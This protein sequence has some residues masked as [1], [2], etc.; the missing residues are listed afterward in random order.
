MAVPRGLIN[1]GYSHG[2]MVNFLLQ[3]R[4][5]VGLEVGDLVCALCCGPFGRLRGKKNCTHLCK[6][7][8]LSFCVK[9]V[10]ITYCIGSVSDQ[11][12]FSCESGSKEVNTKEE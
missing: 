3:S 6:N 12:K 10:I 1:D 7:T 4:N 5:M 2:G 8:F 9:I 11:H